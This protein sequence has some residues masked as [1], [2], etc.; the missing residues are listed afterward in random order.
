MRTSFLGLVALAAT[1]P[2][3]AQNDS[4]GVPPNAPDLDALLG[5]WQAQFGPEWHVHADP[6][7]LHL[8]MLYGGGASSAARPAANVD[9]DWLAL[10]RYWVGET[11]GMTGLTLGELVDEKVVYLPL[12]MGKG[13][14]KLTVRLRQEVA[15]VPV[16]NGFLN[17]LYDTRGTLLSLHN[18]TAPGIAGLNTVPGVSA[19]EALERARELFRRATGF[20]PTKVSDAQ[21]VI[22]QVVRQGVREAHLAY[23]VSTQRIENGELPAGYLWTLRASDGRFL[24]RDDE[25]HAF[26]VTGQVQSMASPGTQADSNSNPE[27]PLVTPYIRLT[28]SAGT[29]NADRDGNFNF[30]GTNTPLNITATYLGLFNN[31]NNQAGA[32]YSITFN[33]VQPNQANVLLMN[34]GPVNLVTAEANGYIHINTM[35]DFIRDTVPTDNTADFV[36]TTNVNI[37]SSCNA[38][39]NGSS[40][41]Y[42]TPGGNCNNTAFSTVV[43]HEY[44]HWLN[45]RYN[46]GNGGDGMGEGNADVWAMYAFDTPLVGQGFFTSG[47]SIRTG[48]NTR[49]YCGDG[50]GGCYGQ[51]HADGEVWMGAAW[52]VR[53]NL[54]NNLGAGLGSATADSIF[55]GWMNAYNQTQIHSIIET[56]WLTLDDDDANINNGTPNYPEINN[57]FLAQGFPGFDL[58]FLS[59]TNVTVLGDTP[60]DVGPYPVDA[61]ITA[62]FT[63]PVQNP[64][65]HWRVNG[66]SFNQVAMA[67]TGGDGYTADIP[68]TGIGVVDYYLSAQDGGGNNDE[69]PDE[70]AAAPLSFTVGTQVNAFAWDFEAATNEGWTVGSPQDT[71]TTGV[72]VRGDPIGTA[73]Q[74][75]NDHTPGVGDV[76]CWFTG[77]GSPGG[78]LGENDVDGGRTTVVSPPLDLAGR[79]GVQVTYWRWY[80]NDTGASPNADVFRVGV[81][82][83]GINW[84]NAQEIGPGGNLTDGGWVESTFSVDS[85]ITPSATTQFRFIAADDGA[86]SIIEAA[87]DDVVVTYL[88]DSCPAPVNYCSTSPNSFSSGALM[89][90]L[91]SQNV[92]HNNFS[93]VIAGGVPNEFGIFYYGMNQDNAPV[94][95]GTRCVGNQFFRLGALQMDILGTAVQAVDFQNPPA[96]AGQI[97]NG[98]VW[99]F[100]FWYRD[101]GVGAGFNFADG[102]QVEFCE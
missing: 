19:E 25:I 3:L 96:L 32:D 33:N 1:A 88:E 14:D 89:S 12:G 42:Y 56:Q 21:L 13:T 50:N 66:G 93:L 8:E 30:V 23:Q 38:F 82:A 59:F 44:G 54:K 20:V 52:K 46:T 70:G 45:V 97:S 47:G 65:L 80:S 101:P 63:S 60:S 51:V 17:A 7:T 77:Q 4:D 64:T 94:G 18:T 67:S 6:A 35:R 83:D 81:S 26:D 75:E 78:S 37:N 87:I 100:S 69:Y 34:P 28:S 2:L 5:S 92:G 41:N 61:D 10:T 71:A 43:G 62:T 91:G 58:A 53:N 39:F 55:V 40:T 49:Q 99:N 102:L 95:N 68:A 72:W 73:A 15:G 22:A 24:R 29:I 86:G 48:N 11:A 79:T 57:G 74:P 84:A 9:A 16:E 31:V 85:F 36:A 90:A 98:E 27:A 76:N